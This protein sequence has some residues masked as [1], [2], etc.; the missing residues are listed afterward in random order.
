MS[1]VREVSF[2]RYIL[3]R[4]EREDGSVCLPVSGFLSDFCIHLNIII[5]VIV[6]LHK[7]STY[8]VSL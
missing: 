2:R 4:E 7:V 6:D 3:E 5:E 1:K 8:R